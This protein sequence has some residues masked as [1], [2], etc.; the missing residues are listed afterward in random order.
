MHMACKYANCI[1]IA[2]KNKVDKS[3][4]TGQDAITSLAMH[5][6]GY[7]RL[8]PVVNRGEYIG[9]HG[10]H[11]RPDWFRRERFNEVVLHDFPGENQHKMFEVFSDD[12]TARMQ[13]TPSPI[14]GLR[15]VQR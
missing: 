14:A 2:H 9:E 3:P 13:S 1:Q 6:A 8:A 5:A 11:M 15:A 4:P 7:V 12:M 10:I